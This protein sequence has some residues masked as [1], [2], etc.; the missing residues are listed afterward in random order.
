MPYGIAPPGFRLPDATHVGAVSLQ[1]AD[2]SR[3]LDYYTDVLGLRRDADDRLTGAA[4]ARTAT[5]RC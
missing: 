1:V 4:G 5:T 2:L 3:S